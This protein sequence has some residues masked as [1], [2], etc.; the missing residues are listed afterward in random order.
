MK[1][2]LSFLVVLLLSGC[3]QTPEL[4]SLPTDEKAVKISEETPK[5]YI[6]EKPTKEQML[7]LEEKT[8][9][10][11][12]IPNLSQREAIVKNAMSY[13][14]KRDGGDCSGFVNLVNSK[15]N[16]P[17]YTA[18]ELNSSYDNA[19]KSRAMYNLMRKKNSAFSDRL[20]YIGDLMF[21]EDTERR[22]SKG[23]GNVAENITHVGIV[24]RVDADGTV[25]FIHH[26]RGKNILDYM[27]LNYPTITKKDGKVINTYMK[28]CPSKKGA[29]VRTDCLNHAFFVAYGTF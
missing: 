13:K 1:Y 3:T 18:K 12:P 24:T 15:N 9:A 19:R 5:E 20:P 25:E 26:S 10:T 21:F 28:K 6:E 2:T 4:A 22:K 11:R 7:V 27:N 23:S 29:V 16:S 17:F 8:H 14:G